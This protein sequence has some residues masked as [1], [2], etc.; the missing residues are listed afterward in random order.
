MKHIIILILFSTFCS[1]QEKY[2][3]DYLIEYERTFLKEDSL[4]KKVFYLTNSKDNSYFAELTLKDSLNYNM[5][6]KHHDKL[7]SFVLVSKFQI[8]EAEA[9]NI[10]CNQITF[11]KNEYKSVIDDYEFSAPKDTVINNKNHQIYNLKS[12]LNFKK[13]K[14]NGSGTNVYIIDNSSISHLPF[15]THPTAYEKW[16]LQNNLPNGLLIEKKHIN[17]FEKDHSTEV[18]I[19]YKKI[20]KNIIIIGDCINYK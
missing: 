6:F 8:N 12:K 11:K 14:R 20:K 2:T 7:H 1:A 15:F 9:I 5:F 4:K 3:F 13:R 17:V 19:S 10:N 18:L 16:K